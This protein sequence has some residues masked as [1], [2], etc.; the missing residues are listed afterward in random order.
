MH[1]GVKLN[2]SDDLCN[3]IIK[4]IGTVEEI[5]NSKEKL[6]QIISGRNSVDL[7]RAFFMHI[8]ML[9]CSGKL[10]LD[11]LKHFRSGF[12][13]E[14]II[15]LEKCV[16]ETEKRA[17]FKD[18]IGDKLKLMKYILDFDSLVATYT[19]PKIIG[20]LITR[21]YCDLTTWSNEIYDLPDVI[22][23]V[24]ADTIANAKNGSEELAVKFLNGQ[25]IPEREKRLCKQT[26]EV[27][28]MVNYG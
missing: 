27:L 5:L 3:N 10:D 11:L 22:L 12:A 19:H 24:I 20:A 16:T 4:Q 7:T 17:L 25:I 28:S 9:I 23:E 26:R 2:Y 8:R 6:K 18:E 13:V 14:Q 15:N 1:Q 21:T